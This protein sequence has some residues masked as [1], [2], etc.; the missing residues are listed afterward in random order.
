MIDRHVIIDT[1]TIQ[2]QHKSMVQAVHQSSGPRKSLGKSMVSTVSKLTYTTLNY[3]IRLVSPTK[4]RQLFNQSSLI[5]LCDDK[6]ILLLKSIYA[7][8]TK[9]MSTQH[10]RVLLFSDLNNI[11]TKHFDA[12]PSTYDINI[13]ITQLQL[14]H[15]LHEYH[16]DADGHNTNSPRVF[17]IDSQCT[18]VEYQIGL[19]RA[20]VHSINNIISIKQQHIDELTIKIKN[21][22]KCKRQN[23]AIQLLKQRKLA[24]SRIDTLL[25]QQYNLQ[26]VCDTLETAVSSTQIVAT[27][28]NARE[29]LQKF[30]LDHTVDDVDDVMNDINESI[31][32]L[33]ITD[34]RLAEP[35]L[36]DTDSG[37]ID[38]DIK[39]MMDEIE[40][41][42]TPSTLSDQGVTPE[43][44]FTTQPLTQHNDPQTKPSIIVTDQPDTRELRTL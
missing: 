24:E 1:D 22:I 43:V 34:Q 39:Q 5:V 17:T 6:S 35:I 23:I 4:Q 37:D 11:I 36:T 10:T 2:Q 8:I 16:T 9:F 32:H 21:N 3:A 42:T 38:N 15:S 18:A 30:E 28:K 27:M 19:V 31:N 33:S 12:T 13:I 26:H 25:Q 41:E 20:Q 29:L 7:S 40:H 14:Y 44:I